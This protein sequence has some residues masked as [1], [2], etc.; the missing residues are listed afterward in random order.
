MSHFLPD[1]KLE[2]MLEALAVKMPSLN[3]ELV[4]LSFLI[5]LVHTN[6]HIEHNERLH[7]HNL[8]ESL[9][10]ALLAIYAHSNHEILPSELSNILHLTRTSATRLSDEL[11]QNKWIT[12]TTHPVDR[13]KIMLK[14]TDAG[15]KL[16]QKVS[17]ET[18]EVHHRIW[19]DLT[20][21]ECEQLQQ[22]LS[23]LLNAA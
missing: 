21:E 12:R 5:R 4:M 11:V 3:V 8:S 15:E 19:S 22:L 7:Q 23:K 20:K 1:P 2:A 18:N 14:L 9:W 17:P 13:R 6:I 16:I 10:H